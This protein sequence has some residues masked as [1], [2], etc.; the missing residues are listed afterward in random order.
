MMVGKRERL[1][2]AT[3]FIF[4]LFVS[5]A[6]C[7]TYKTLRLATGSPYELGLIDK[8]YKKFKEKVP[9]NIVVKK[10]GSGKSLSLLR[11]GKVDVCIVHAPELE[12]KAQKD[13]WAKDRTYIFANDFVIVGPKSDP[14]G[15]RSCRDVVCAYRKIAKTRSLFFSRGDNSGT[16]RKELAIWKMAGIKPKGSWY[17]VTKNFMMASLLEAN[18][19]GG[20]FM[21][22][23]STYIVARKKYPNLKL[24][25]LFQGDPILINRYH[26][27][28]GN[29]EVN[30][31]V[32]YKLAKRFVD[33]LVSEKCQKIIKNYGK[34]EFGEP[35]YFCRSHLFGKVIIFHA[36]SLSVPFSKIE[37]AF[38]S[39]HEG[40]DVVRES[41]GSVKCARLVVDLKKPCDILASADV[42]VIKNL[43]YPKYASSWVCFATNSMVI[44]FSSKSRY[45]QIINSRNWYKIL[46]KNGVSFGHSDPN[47]DPCGYRTVILMRLAK[48]YYKD[49]NIPQLL[50]KA[51]IRPKSVELFGLLETGNLDYAFEYRS[52]S[53]Q[54]NL[55]FLELPKEINLSDPKMNKNY[56]K[57][58]VEIRGKKPGEKIKIYGKAITYAAAI[59]SNAPH[60]GFAKEFMRFLL[61]KD[62]GLKIIKE[63]GQVP[64]FPPMVYGK[65][66]HQPGEMI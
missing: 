44:A 14:A 13:G 59:L 5:E 29:P 45:S 22:D 66:K 55:K 37:K 34:K 8:L 38:E 64:L 19:G 46:A 56:K 47:L 6:I 52:V 30:P 54:H 28:C 42:E 43:L 49:K 31:N 15:I 39:T 62:K 33:F 63:C 48:E 2:L 50:K 40:V 60:K 58:W 35:L 25:I 27:L 57:V 23:R 26:A 10:A 4:F 17:K 7:V 1:F 11:S 20:Y 36:G 12:L 51:L 18:R 41:H 9:C 21:S 16:N 53:I 65:V 24:R 32:N 3:V 61:D